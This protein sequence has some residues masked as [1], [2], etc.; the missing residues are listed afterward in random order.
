MVGIPL[1]LITMFS[2]AIL[3]GVMTLWSM[4]L[5]AKAQAHSQL[6]DKVGIEA[7]RQD[8]ARTYGG[9]DEKFSFTRR[10]LAIMAVFS[11]IVLPKLAALWGLP[12]VTVGYTEFDPGF[13]FFTEGKDVIKWITATGFVI[14]PLDTHFCSAVAGLY[15]GSSTVRNA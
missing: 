1:E 12:P 9:K 4:S 8:A 15:F 14:T 3:G 6:M 11:V 2:S 10:T 13:W 7:K 5:K